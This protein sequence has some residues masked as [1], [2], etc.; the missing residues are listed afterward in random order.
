MPVHHTLIRY[1]KDSGRFQV[2]VQVLVLVLW[3][4]MGFF[5]EKTLG[6][7]MRTF[8]GVFLRGLCRFQALNLSVG[9]DALV[10]G[11][12]IILSQMAVDL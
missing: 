11:F 6:F 5:F 10:G 8:L 7:S 4:V 12:C 9:S 3:R 1:L 2:H